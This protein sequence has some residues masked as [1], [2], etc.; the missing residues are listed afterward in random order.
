MST[1]GPSAPPAEGKR[2]PWSAI[3]AGLRAQVEDQLG[4]RVVRAVTQ[5]GGF[6]PGVAARLELESGARA[7]IKAVGDINPDSPGLHRAEARITAALPASTPAPR[8]LA[9][10]DSDGW[11]IL[12][13]EDVDGRMPRQPWEP[14][15]LRL[16]LGALTDLNRALTPS[17]IEAP[18]AA[19][20]FR[21]LGTS[22]HEFGQALAAGSIE[23]ADL[24]PWAGRHLDQLMDTESRWGA[25]VSGCSLTHGDMRADNLLLAGERV[26]FVDWPWACLAAPWFDLVIMLPSIA[27]QGGPPPEDVLAGHPLTHAADPDAITVAVAALAG[28]FCWTGRLPDPPGLPTLRAFQRAHAEVTLNW[29]RERT[30][31]R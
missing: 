2:L 28:M 24:P 31:W 23:L 29:V 27:L 8:L 6:S 12:L 16:V 7:F 19:T 18:L 3:P 11:V 30:D 15:E 26:V 9:S 13:F 21:N 20:R 4:G 5:P 1:T 14:A 17:P 10:V 22:W 25:A